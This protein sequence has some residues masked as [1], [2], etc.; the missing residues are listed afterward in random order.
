VDMVASCRSLVWLRLCPRHARF[1]SWAATY[2][3][4]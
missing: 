1:A 2:L 4:A 3:S